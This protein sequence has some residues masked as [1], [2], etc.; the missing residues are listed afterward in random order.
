M[1]A[2]V[3]NVLGWILTVVVVLALA[4]VF[5]RLYKWYQSTKQEGSTSSTAMKRDSSKRSV[6]SFNIFNDEETQAT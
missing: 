2:K 3:R 4:Y 5:Y 6:G 1:V